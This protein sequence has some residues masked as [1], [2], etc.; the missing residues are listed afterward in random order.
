[1]NGKIKRNTR[2][3]DVIESL[4]KNDGEPEWF[5]LR[6]FVQIYVDV[7]PSERSDCVRGGSIQSERYVECGSL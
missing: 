5:F 3:Y 4:M 1:M 7:S 2:V 6:R